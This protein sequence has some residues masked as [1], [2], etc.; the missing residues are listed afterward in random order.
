MPIRLVEKEEELPSSSLQDISFEEAKD[1]LTD[2]SVY[3]K[4]STSDKSS[5]SREIFAE[6]SQMERR[7]YEFWKRF[8]TNKAI[9]P[10]KATIYFVLLLKRLLGDSFAIRFLE[11]RERRTIKEYESLRSSIPEK[12]KEDFEQIIQDERGHETK[13]ADQV[14]QSY[15][16]YI[17]FIILGLSDA[18]VEIAGIHAGSLGIYNSTELSGLAGIIAGAA[19]SLAMASAAYAQAKQGFQGSP[20]LAAAYTG[21]SY[22]IAAVILALPYFLTRTMIVA[23][24]SSVTAGVVIIAFVSWYNAIMSGNLFKKDFIQ[25]A[26][27]MLGATL[28]LFAF[29]LVIRSIFGI[30]I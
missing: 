22:F 24:S 30:T 17:S 25:F 13:F 23:I 10:K 4:L 21:G 7:H 15:I 27:I 26:S 29:G 14:E 12:D 5:K 8:V 3:K 1:E 18:L 19:A 11:H 6:L 9:R 16:K 20:G 2:Y 28:A